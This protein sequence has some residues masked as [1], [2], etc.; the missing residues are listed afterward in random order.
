MYLYHPIS[1]TFTKKCEKNVLFSAIFLLS[2][3]IKKRGIF[4]GDEEENFYMYK[5]RYLR[6][7]WIAAAA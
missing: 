4:V 5:R 7:M 6:E 1:L 2:L 3:S